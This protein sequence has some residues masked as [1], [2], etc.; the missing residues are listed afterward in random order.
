[1]LGTIDYLEW[2]GRTIAPAA[3][4]TRRA[5]LVAAMEGCIAYERMLGERLLAGLR[6]IQGLQPLRP[7]DMEGRVPTFAFTIDGHSPDAVAETS[8][9]RST[10]T[11]GPAISTRSS[12]SRASACG[13]A[14]DWSGSGSAITA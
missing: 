9:A 10:S 6:T 5:A 4:A 8:G 2:L 3:P 11:P 13:R 7:A 14:A 12:R 1:M